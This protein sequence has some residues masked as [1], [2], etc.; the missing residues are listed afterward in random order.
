MGNEPRVIHQATLAVGDFIEKKYRVVRLLDEGG[1]GCVYHAIHEPLGR[2]VAVKVLKPVLNEEPDKREKRHRRFLREASL[3]S[4]LNHPNTIT[5]FDY[6]ELD[7]NRG[8]F[9]VMEFL[10]GI[11]LRDLMSRQGALDV[12]TA[13]HIATQIAGSLAD[14]HQ[15]GV[16]HRDLKPPN[17]MLVQRGAD[18]H[19]VKVVDFGL[20][21]DI[22]ENSEDDTLTQENTFVGSPL[23]MAPERFLSKDADFP[24]VDIY[25][26]GVVLYEMLVGRPPFV[27]QSE[28]TLH[29]LIMQHIQADPP[30]MRSFKPDLQLPDGLE[31]LV[32]KCLSKKPEN[33]F[34]S[35]DTLVHLLQSC[36]AGQ[37]ARSVTAITGRSVPFN[38]GGQDATSDAFRRNDT[39]VG[40]L[41][42]TGEHTL[43]DIPSNIEERVPINALLAGTSG[44][45][46]E[47]RHPG[48][49]RRAILAVIGLIA[50]IA[51][52]MAIVLTRSPDLTEF[53]L[54]SDPPG[55]MVYLDNRYLGQ[56][57]LRMALEVT[58]ESALRFSQ[59][60]FRD[61]HFG[62]GPNPGSTVNVHAVLS[63]DV[64]EQPVAVDPAPKAPVEVA[65][66]P[67][68]VEQPPSRADAEP[69][70][71]RPGKK[72]N[73]TRPRRDPPASTPTATGAPQIKLDR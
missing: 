8:F 14:A 19:F 4:R 33:R 51:A 7:D 30:P 42:D 28:S 56:T 15:A 61:Y 31:M 23:Y 21:K 25:A 50:V 60:G 69:N 32:M 67:E 38:P 57:P 2:D 37:P 58:P 40:G 18:S 43:Q 39:G 27:R 46:V 36:A 41:Q 68:I 54:N 29:Q 35:M 49:S 59:D 10:K 34:E 62:V 71:P 66:A 48:A 24:S 45:T 5:I 3:S 20:V 65:D 63:P 47:G 13:I 22:S 11:S 53:S 64:V 16:I 26:L 73:T 6:G 44:A 1:M 9:F 70:E 17:V 72:V 55:A 52:L 12:P